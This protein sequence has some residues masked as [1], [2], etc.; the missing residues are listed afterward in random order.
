MKSGYEE[1]TAVNSEIEIQRIAIN[2]SDSFK[3]GQKKI[4]VSLYPE[5]LGKVDIEIKS[6]NNS[7]TQIRII[8]HNKDSYDLVASEIGVL[9]NAIK[10]IATEGTKLNLELND[11]SQQQDNLQNQSNNGQ[12]GSN[13]NQQFI[14][15]NKGEFS[16][17][18]GEIEVESLSKLEPTA[19]SN[20]G[21]ADITNQ[22]N[23]VI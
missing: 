9:G 5:Q 2:I 11:G 20:D 12:N 13:Q 23:V 14:I 3:V 15:N 6:I 10:E 8:T 4:S 1:S 17:F 16:I 18:D 7:I 22:L 21:T 19:A